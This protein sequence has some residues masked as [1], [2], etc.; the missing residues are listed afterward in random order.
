[1]KGKTKER[2][3]EGLITFS[4]LFIEKNKKIESSATG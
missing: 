3:M 4:F 2:R 1:M